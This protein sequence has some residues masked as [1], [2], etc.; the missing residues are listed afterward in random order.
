MNYEIRDCIDAGTEYCP[1]HL[2]ETGDCI[3]C[4]QLSGKKF[5]DCINWKGVCI[6]QEYVWNKEKSKTGRR[7]Y[8]CKISKK[9]LVEKNVVIFDI[10]APHE[11][12]KNLV[13]PGSYVFLRTDKTSQFYDVP[14]SMMDVDMEEN[15]LKVAIEIKGIKTKSINMLKEGDNILVRGPY[16]NGDLGLR[17]IYKSREGTSI[18]IAR[19][20]GQAPMVPVLKKLYANGNKIIVI[21][22]KGKYKDIF[23]KKYLDMC[24]CTV[25]ECNTLQSGGLSEELKNKITRLME[26][27]KINLIH[28]AGPDILNYKVLEYIEDKVDFSCCNNA[29]MCCGEGVCGACATRYKGSRVKKLC[30]VQIEP[31]Y[32]FEGRRLI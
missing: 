8:S 28:C 12:V 6:Y 2:A 10:A 25:I 1:C 31:K 7:I 18:I 21:M 17:N 9:E 13:H 24:N 32:L 3:I 11:L 26:N 30:K 15:I 22:D 23:I 14:I 27:E 5:C 16:W 20:I 4:S 19:G 29:K